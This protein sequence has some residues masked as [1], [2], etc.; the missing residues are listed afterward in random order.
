MYYVVT[1][2]FFYFIVFFN[3]LI[4]TQ[5]HTFQFLSNFNSIIEIN[6]Y[7]KF[8]HKLSLDLDLNVYTDETIVYT[9]P[10]VILFQIKIHFRSISVNVE[11]SFQ[12]SKNEKKSYIYL[13]EIIFLTYESG[14][15]HI[16]AILPYT[17][18]VYIIK[19]SL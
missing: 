5:F 2:E 14:M 18:W 3:S 10:T 1:L 12:T 19:T 6:I 11:S 13:T 9:V 8:F 17:V 7:I 15:H 4:L 16:R